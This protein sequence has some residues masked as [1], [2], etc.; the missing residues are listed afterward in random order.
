MLLSISLI[1][2]GGMLA[3]KLVSLVR[4]PPLTGMLVTGILIGPYCLNLI[5]SSVLNISSELRRIALIIILIRAGLNLKT[6]D[7]KKAGRPAFLMCFVPASFEILGMCLIAPALLQITL[8]EALLLGSVV[9]AV[10]PAVIVPHMIRIM[11]QGYGQERAVPQMVLAGASCDDV[12][13]IVLFSC[14][15]SLVSTGSFRAVSLLRIPVSILL[16]SG[17]GI[18]CG[19]VFSRAAERFRPQKTVMTVILLCLSFVLVSIEDQINSTV[20]FSGLI[21]VMAM[22]MTC[23]HLIPGKASEVSAQSGELWKAAQVILF[24]LVGAAVEIQYAL[25]ASGIAALVIFLVLLFRMAGV[26]VS[27]ARS[28]YTKKERLFAMI[29]YTPK[30]TVQA[31]IGPLPLAMG[32]SC[33]PLVLTVAVCAILFTAP[34]GAFLIDL[35]YAKLLKKTSVH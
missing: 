30:A 24:V 33:G 23:A 27:T 19:I 8:A 3:G 11:E 10:S 21:G 1:L 9:A 14:F 4:L 35:T 31:A 22:G 28:H 2:L 26:L 5:D 32:L 29:A 18:L 12:F 6:E 17:A 13:V 16:G 20:G 7:L 34:A 15:A 25:H